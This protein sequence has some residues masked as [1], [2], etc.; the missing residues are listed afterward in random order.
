MRHKDN[1]ISAAGIITLG[2]LP[3][4]YGGVTNQNSGMLWLGYLLLGLGLATPPFL[5]LFKNKR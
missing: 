2:S 5:K 1:I 3:V 4:L